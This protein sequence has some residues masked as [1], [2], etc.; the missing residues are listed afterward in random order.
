M[1]NFIKCFMREEYGVW[2]CIGPGTLLLP[3]GRIQVTPGIVLVRGTPFMNVEVAKL[4]DEHYE[5]NQSA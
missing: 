2:R 4:L 3:T 5:K 1:H